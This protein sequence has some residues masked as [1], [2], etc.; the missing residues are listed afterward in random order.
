[1]LGDESRSTTG[2]VLYHWYM[3]FEVTHIPLGRRSSWKELLFV[4]SL[5]YLLFVNIT[6]LDDNSKFSSSGGENL[7]RGSDPRG[8][9]AHS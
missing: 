7:S 9:E 5:G 4:N 3:H 1:M 6:C 8:F 2:V